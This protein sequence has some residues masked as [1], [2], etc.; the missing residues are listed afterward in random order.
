MAE[1]PL[2]ASDQTDAALVEKVRDFLLWADT[3]HPQ[4]VESLG[5]A[6][7]R[8]APADPIGEIERLTA[9]TTP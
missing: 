4:V 3:E 9:A 2:I 6:R 8:P 7:F 1:G 5:F